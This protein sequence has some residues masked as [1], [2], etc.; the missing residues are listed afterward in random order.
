MLRIWIPLIVSFFFGPQ[1]NAQSIYN[2]F[3]ND[4]SDTRYGKPETITGLR[5]FS[6][7]KDT[8]YYRDSFDYKGHIVTQKEFVK[9]TLASSIQYQYD[10]IKNRLTGETRE[11]FGKN[12][13]K[14]LV[15]YDYDDNNR[16]ILIINTDSAGHPTSLCQ[17][18]TNNNA[19]PVELIRT[20]ADKTYSWQ[21]LEYFPDK[22]SAVVTIYYD[23]GRIQTR[24]TLPMDWHKPAILKK[25]TDVLNRN[26]DIV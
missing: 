16:L 4:R 18:K 20:I 12:Y 5:Y 26:G 1:A 10:T 24:D 13:Y 9:G 19:E 6:R 3:S 23:D 21:K 2:L 22:N 15:V 7:Q 14:E 25:H 8:T 11:T 17:V